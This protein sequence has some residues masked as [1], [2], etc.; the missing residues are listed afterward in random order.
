[1]L[2]SIFAPACDASTD[3]CTFSAATTGVPRARPSTKARREEDRWIIGSSPSRR[4]E[5]IVPLMPS[6]EGARPGWERRDDR[7]LLRVVDDAL[8][9][10]YRLGGDHLACRVGCTECCIGPFPITLVD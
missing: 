7:R 6:R 9:D 8:A 1:M 2:R 10:G 4:R 5:C 3:S